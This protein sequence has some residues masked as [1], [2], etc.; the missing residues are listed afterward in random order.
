[1]KSFLLRGTSN[2]LY[3]LLHELNFRV[4]SKYTNIDYGIEH[5]TSTQDGK[6]A[7][8]GQNSHFGK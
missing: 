4:L 2:Y 3:F 6:M 7:E 5:L 1:M 8:N